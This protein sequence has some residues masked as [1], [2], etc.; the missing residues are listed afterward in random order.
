MGLVKNKLGKKYRILVVLSLALVLILG[1]VTYFITYGDRII[2]F[3]TDPDYLESG[4][5][6]NK[7]YVNDLD[8][9]YNYY[10]GLNYTDNDGT[11]PSE[12]NK[13]IY[14]DSNLV[15]VKITYSSR[16]KANHV[17]YVSLTER[18]D[19]YIY[20]KTFDVNDNG[21]A[22]KGDDYILIQLIDNPFTDRPSNMGFNGW[23]SSY[24]GVVLSYD[25]D[26]YLRY[27]KV[28]VSYDEDKPRKIDITFNASWV[29]A[30][31][32][33]V[34]N[35]FNNAIG[36][37]Y[38][39][40]M[41]RVETVISDYGDYYYSVNIGFY[42]SYAGY[43]NSNG[44]YQS[45][46][47]CY[48]FNGC[49]YYE[50]LNGDNYV[51]GKTYY[52]LVNG[53][54]TSSGNGEIT[55]E[56]KEIE[57][58]QG[59]N[60]ASF[61]RK[62][63][64]S[65]GSSYAGY[66]NSSGEYQNSGTC[67]SN[68]CEYYE[69]IQYYDSNL[70]EEINDANDEYYYLVT[71]DTNILV[72]NQN[73]SGGWSDNGDYPFTITSVNNQ[74]S[75]NVTWQVNSAINCYNDVNIENVKVYYPNQFNGTFDPPTNTNTNGVLYGRYN[76]VRIG[77][78]IV[79]N[80]NYYTFRSIVFGFGNSATGSNG[81][82]TKYRVLLE[83]GFYNSISL[84]NGA[85]SGSRSSLYLSNLSEYGND[86]DRV[87][88]N[89]SNLDVYYCASGVWSGSAVYASS[90]SSSSSDVILN[91]VV[92]SGTFGRVK[93][94]LSSGIYVGGRTGGTQYAVRQATV[95]GG[96]IFNLIGGPLSATSRENY[97]DVYIYMLGGSVDAVV[98]GAGTTATY[99]NRIIQITGG[100]VNY[101]VFGGS[102]GYE[103]SSGDGTLNGSSYVYVG[104]DA[105]IGKEEYMTADNEGLYG[106]LAG[107]VFGIGNGNTQA[108][109]IGT[110]NNSTVIID[111]SATIL[112]N[113]YGGG[114][115]GATG[116]SSSVTSSFTKIVINGGIVKGSV[117]GGGNKNGSGDANKSSSINIKMYNGNV[118]GSI[119][120]GSNEEGVIYGSVDVNIYGGEVGNSV[121]GGG[122]GGISN[123]SSGTY[124]RNQVNITVGDSDSKYT[125][126]INGSV[127]GGSAY[128]TV[129]GVSNSTN[130]STDDT[131]VVINKGIISSVFGGGQGDSTYT[132]YVLGD[133]FVTVNDGLI[134]NL[135]GGNDKSGIP[136]GQITVTI[137][138]GTIENTYGGGNETSAN[139]TYVYLN[140]GVSSKIFGGSNVTGDVNTSYVT[141]TDGNATYIY[142]GNNQ[143]GK[144][145][146]T[147][148]LVTGGNIETVFGGGEATSVENSSNV[149]IKSRVQTVY[150]GSNLMGN[151][152]VCNITLED[153]IVDSLYGG[154]NQGGIATTTNISVSGKYVYNLYGG[155]NK[156][157]TKTTNIKAYYGTIYNLYGGGMESGADETNVN[158]GGTVVN[159]LYGGSNKSGLVKKT[160]IKNIT[161]GVNDNVNVSVTYGESSQHNQQDTTYKSSENIKVKIT[162][163]SSNQ[164]NT[165][166]LYILTSEGF[167]GNNWSN[168]KIIGIEDGYFID[169]TNQYYGTNVISG[170]GSYEFDF[171]VHSQ[172]D[173]ED[174]IIYGYYFIGYDS[175]N[176]KYVSS[177][178]VS[179]MYGGN[180]YGGQTNDAYIDLT[181]GVIGNIY[182]G[183]NK[184][185]TGTTNVDVSN[186]KIINSIY[187]GGN[188]ASVE[189]VTVL[190]SGSTIGTSQSNG[191]IYGGGNKASVDTSVSLTLEND[192][193]VY[194]SV[195]GGG[196]LGEVKGTV[197]TI[198]SDSTITN[199]IYGAGNKA[200]VGT[201]S[202]VVAT[203]LKVTNT[204]AS[205]VYGGGNAALTN[206]STSVIIKGST[207]DNIYGGGNG[208][209][210]S[211]SGDETGESNLA[212]VS[213]NTE[214][215]VDGD[216]TVSNV[217]GG[218]N[219]GMVLGNTSVKV[220]KCK[221]L[222][223][224]YGGGNASIVGIDTYLYVSNATVLNSVYAGGNGVMA[225]VWGSTKVD[226]D[227][228]TNIANHVFGSGNAASTGKLEN[229]NSFG[230]V[231]IAGGIIGKNVY[232]GANT[233]VL[234]GTTNVNIGKNVVTNANLILS[235]ISIGGTVFGGGEANAGG[236]E[237]YDFTFISVTKGININIDGTGYDNFDIDGSIFGSGNASSTSGSSYVNIYNYGSITDV[238]RNISIQR[239]SVVVID[240]SYMLLSGA[241]D[242]T[243]EFSNK[244]Y[245]LS[246]IDELKLRNSSVLY[247]R[248]GANLV[249]KFSSVL[250]EDGVEVKASATIDND[251][252]TFSRNVNNRIYMEQGGGNLNISRSEVAADDVGD[253]SGMTFFGMYTL[254][255]NGNIITALYSD[256]EYNQVVSS[257]DIYYFSAGSAVLGRHLVNH[258]ITVDGF[259]SNFGN[260]DGDKIIIKYIEPTP[261]DAEFY[262][263]SIGEAVKSYNVSLAASKFSTLG[264]NEISLIQ[265][266]SP[267]TKFYILG[268]NFSNLDSD[269]K[270]VNYEDI[271]RVAETEDDANTIFGLTMK[272][273]QVGWLNNGSTNFVTEGDKDIV[274]TTQ[275]ERE[276]YNNIPS[277]VFYLYHS[278]NL[279]KAGSWGTVT[280]S[281]SAITPVDE[282][283]SSVERIN[284][285]IDLSSILF[286][287]DEY[288]GTIAPGKKY[289]MFANS[290]VDITTKSSFSAYYS[291]FV[292][293]DTSPY[294]E[295]YYRSLVSSLVFP[296]DT[297]ITMIDLHDKDKPVYYYY[298]VDS[299]DYN[300]ALAEYNIYNEASYL[301]S[302]F[303][304]MG[305]VSDNNNY[306]DEYYNEIYYSSGVALEEFIFMVDFKDANINSDLL[307]NSLLI[308]LRNAEGQTLISV[309]GIEQQTLKYN[310]YANT[311]AVIELDGSIS[312]NPLYLGNSTN[313]TIDTN[314]VQQKRGDSTI[315]DATFDDEKLGIKIS[316]FD[317]NN[318]LLSAQDLMGVSFTYNGNKY[319]PRYDGT[320]R[321]KISD[322]V[323]NARSRIVF[324]TGTSKLTTGEYT[325]LVE[326]FGSY[327][328]IYY[329][330]V[331]SER[332]EMKL[333]IID[334]PYG[335]KVQA[336]GDSIFIDKD[337]GVVNA[338]LNNMYVFK[339]N[340]ASELE[341]ANLRVK[342]QRRNYDSIYTDSYDLVN[343]LD[344][345]TETLTGTSN[346]WE[347]VL[348]NSPIDNVN[349]NYTF[350]ENLITGT[351]KLVVS[352]YDGNNYIGEAYQ[353][354]IIK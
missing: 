183:G 56:V 195:Y 168:S 219:L 76:N 161:S 299:S 346:E 132:P 33:M 57:E 273:G 325:I 2:D 31:V 304:R 251:A 269:I 47:Y 318:N 43:Y 29:V 188:E 319:Y 32:E 127:Y 108:S 75:Y 224:V 176:N 1:N 320:T 6:S 24:S 340:Y 351:Y 164:I 333:N 98:G 220:G 329:G 23:I 249:K 41:K 109:T 236:S 143:G 296:V 231:N 258:D 157:E 192:T 165:W 200:T 130:L 126:I 64:I 252:G 295:G 131:S 62:K 354:I 287:T 201:D 261:A 12:V 93:D 123:S 227:N 302:K 162:N 36:N 15:Q 335:L 217:Y 305:S 103:G 343:L 284:I 50:K 306:N 270:L 216:T 82:P 280:V 274:G 256:Y 160:N 254:D 311:S 198:V 218:G 58:Y 170:N 87:S 238:K 244:M 155:G 89:N 344:Y 148:V 289:E 124:V 35:S 92:K 61:Y 114:N 141:A 283:N 326:S 243:N 293:S 79:K 348:S 197:S 53:T 119:Y 129:N 90:N 172:V 349:Y 66:Y 180:N 179:N 322:K 277:L 113:V 324:D 73:I 67:G 26:Y 22:D 154:N 290:K 18:Q 78:G 199:N 42:T 255:R 275:Y 328:G 68:S 116:I 339:V 139:T 48:S 5:V 212:K 194:G 37:L 342:L 253:V 101:A 242:R 120:G 246:R 59:I 169:E 63:T 111:G 96:N 337:S 135:Y 267:N 353:Y 174:Y 228:S 147:N 97:N 107:N 193:K 85:T 51:S 27:A 184:A 177:L 83:S 202:S 313:M 312:K 121:Y 303:V 91:L 310:L 301:L 345:I 11:Y 39:A 208:E 221:I 226:I 122:R 309:L 99:G 14:T 145:G 77:R 327:D 204:N 4:I 112:G 16:D 173:Y 106:A 34:G 266:V 268:V 17:G 233:S 265:H 317:S 235:D 30:K 150:G 187:G 288:E 205:S 189:E 334:T 222:D 181:S 214:V 134:T 271:P 210:S 171:H 46:G 321:I 341:N 104:G 352:L 185:E 286:A 245:T 350:K 52:S 55:P 166:D 19:T 9:T 45:S 146:T 137:N 156:A 332:I 136:N 142:G 294:K 347:Y 178:D 223:S 300:D 8:K 3:S 133:I 10:M 125:P 100:V 316:I 65:R 285:N 279:T 281:I 206:G 80:G 257:G 331:T 215:L 151:I 84:S 25:S 110:C 263:W 298:V 175:S 211:V 248:K 49:T 158:L 86:Y 186:T 247:L 153:G 191:Y 225:K 239:A 95:M 338:S 262:L 264:I 159:N 230:I 81:S 241:T 240:N 152:P 128:G 234:Y 330:P 315:Y 291:L 323:A 229:D 203:D 13:N 167:I 272:S 278:K 307:N 44:V 54:M 38:T 105:V 7:V 276:N 74:N 28:P 297:K 69:L 102:N 196:N 209:E 117:Y 237:V 308:E 314:F 232:G 149:T 282:I 21:T 115:Y 71:R 118:V 163:N 138:G 250:L 207:L 88:D 20:F 259:Y 190:V 140:G 40:G 94:D 72:I 70:D 182:G 336:V 213:G 292:D 60:M 144:T 260:E